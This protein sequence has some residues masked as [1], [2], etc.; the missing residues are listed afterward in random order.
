MVRRATGAAVTAVL[1]VLALAFLLLAPPTPA[2][3]AEPVSDCT[4]TSGVIVAVDFSHFGGHVERGCA[5]TPTTGF[6]AIH[7]AGFTTEGDDHDGPEF[8]CRID[9]DPTPA[10]QSCRT[11]PPASAYWS[12]WH[13]DPGKNTWQFSEEGAASTHPQP[14]SVDAWVFGSTE[15]G[16]SHGEPTFSPASVHA[17]RVT[18][19]P[20]P[21]SRQPRPT[22]AP[23]TTAKP[24][25]ST[26]VSSSPTPTA[27]PA[28]RH[29]RPHSATRLATASASPDP[30]L[31]TTGPL[32]T[33][34]SP[35]ASRVSAS[36]GTPTGVLIGVPLVVVVAAVAG[37]VSWRRRRASS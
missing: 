25:R 4:T 9:G 21:T 32:V 10:E 13:A 22:A 1:A 20:T 14:G 8:I 34:V 35:A 31:S 24:G 26:G 17:T 6:N 18:A 11:T 5:A 33:D 29:R 7:S 3:S 28:L 15:G 37:L 19:T 27:T 16:G 12:Y 2:A 23:R 30:S 36:R